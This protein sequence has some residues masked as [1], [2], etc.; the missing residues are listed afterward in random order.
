MPRLLDKQFLLTGYL[1]ILIRHQFARGG[2]ERPTVTIITPQ[3]TRERGCQL[4][5]IF[6]FPL[7][8]VHKELTK[9]GIMVSVGRVMGEG[10]GGGGDGMVYSPCFLLPV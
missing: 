7:K 3:D 6:S 5:V 9:R 2:I 10:S 4:S 1:E 8:Q